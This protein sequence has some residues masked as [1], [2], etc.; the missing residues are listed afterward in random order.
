[1]ISGPDNLSIQPLI[2]VCIPVF[3]GD[4]F[5]REAVDSVL[6]QTENNFELVIVD[7]CST[8]RTLEIVAQYNDARITVF[9]NTCNL[10]PVP[11]FNRCI[12]LAKGEFIV[13]LPH[14]DLLLPTA[15]ET[16]SKALISDPQ[17]GLAYSSYYIIDGKGKRSYLSLTY[18]EDKVM[19]GNEAFTRLAGGNPIQCAMIRRE[20]YSRLGSWDPNLKL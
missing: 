9:K 11:N 15:L 10:G 1:M 16:L 7:N 2:S 17:V 19:S 3:N 8:D 18:D 12:E 5:I 14:D 4:N 13:L 20:V 6:N